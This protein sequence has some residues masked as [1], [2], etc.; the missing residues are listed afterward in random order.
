LSY[1][2]Q[3][4]HFEF[5]QRLGTI[6]V[7]QTTQRSDSLIMKKFISYILA[8]T[9][10]LSL[11]ACGGGN[12]NNNTAK[13]NTK[14][15]ETA[16]AKGASKLH[17]TGKNW[18]WDKTTYTV[19]ANQPVTITLSNKLGY[20]V[21]KIDKT[22]VEVSMDKPQTFLFKKAGTYTIRCGVICGAG[23]QTMTAKLIVE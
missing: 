9:L 16:D 6:V 11:T 18:K 4:R 17:I 19:K 20:H 15:V 3:I 2:S 22:G 1:S 8:T 7:V 14:L 21:V 10:L 23:H 13:L 5:A 12:G